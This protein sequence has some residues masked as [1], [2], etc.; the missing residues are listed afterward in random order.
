MGH[1]RRGNADNL[2]GYL[3][4]PRATRRATQGQTAHGVW[5]H[6]L[7]ASPQAATHNSVFTQLEHARSETLA[8]L[9]VRLGYGEADSH[10]FIEHTAKRARDILTEHGYPPAAFIAAPGVWHSD[11]AMYDWLGPEGFL[12]YLDLFAPV[13]ASRAATVRLQAR[14]APN[15]QRTQGA[16]LAADELA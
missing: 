14:L 3:L 12:F 10:D 6:W 7:T 15:G 4:T 2:A 1:R 16:T 8:N 9:T 13:T 5:C 11:I